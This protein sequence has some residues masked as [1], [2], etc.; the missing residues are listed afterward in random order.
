MSVGPCLLAVA[1]VEGALCPHINSAVG[2]MATQTHMQQD[3]WVVP[4][5]QLP[6]QHLAI[7]KADRVQ[8]RSLGMR[9]AA[10]LC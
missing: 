5:T 7:V 3:I 4:A 8:L 1:A 6:T 9:R 10:L 2:R